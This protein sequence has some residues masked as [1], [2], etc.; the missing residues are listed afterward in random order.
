MKYF[1]EIFRRAWVKGLNET[2][3]TGDIGVTDWVISKEFDIQSNP[4]NETIII[5]SK[6]REKFF[7]TYAYDC[8]R[9]LTAAI[10]T[11][12]E[13][14]SYNKRTKELAW[15]IIKTY[16]SAFYSAHSILRLCGFGVMFINQKLSKSLLDVASLQDGIVGESFKINSSACFFTVDSNNLFITLE[17]NKSGSQAHQLLWKKFGAFLKN[18]SDDYLSAGESRVEKQNASQQLTNL[19]DILKQY[20]CVRYSNWLSQVRNDVSYMHKYGLWHPYKKQ[21]SQDTKELNRCSPKFLS[22]SGIFQQDVTLWNTKTDLVRFFLACKFIVGLALLTAHDM[23]KRNPSSKS[24]LKG[25]PLK[26]L[27]TTSR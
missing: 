4:S 19:V 27:L 9:F 21:Y 3:K 10:E 12:R 18:V 26:L 8:S 25:G 11:G 13:I 14:E 16:Y 6:N 7:S 1:E 22:H 15:L 5:S 23:A 17:V 20:N 24:F 2:Q